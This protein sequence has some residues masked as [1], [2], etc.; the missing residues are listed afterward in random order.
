MALETWELKG[1]EVSWQNLSKEELNREMSRYAMEWNTEKVQALLDFMKSKDNP[2]EAGNYHANFKDKYNEFKNDIGKKNRE[3]GALKRSLKGKTWSEKDVI[4]IK[5]Q[6][7][8]KEINDAWKNF[9]KA[10]M[11]NYVDTVGTKID[12]TEKAKDDEINRLKWEL[13]WIVSHGPSLSE[14]FSIER[15]RLVTLNDGIMKLEQDKE[16]YPKNVLIYLMGL[17]NSKIIWIRG[18]KNGLK[19]TWMKIAW[20]WNSDD[21]KENLQNFEES[22]KI[23]PDDSQWT[24]WLK[25]QLQEH[26]HN[27]KQAYVDQQKKSVWF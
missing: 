11:D 3:L 13:S 26:L 27:A 18:V 6:E 9:F 23:K 8:E 16:N 22:I 15:R 19:R 12:A 4:E 5:I 7:K 17:S 10:D 20:K 2:D 14:Y 25:K 24:M 1:L 21:I